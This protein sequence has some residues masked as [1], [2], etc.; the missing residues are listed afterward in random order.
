MRSETSTQC[1]SSLRL[2]LASIEEDRN[3]IAAQDIV[4]GLGSVSIRTQ[5]SVSSPIAEPLRHESGRTE[6]RKEQVRRSDVVFP[7]GLRYGEQSGERYPRRQ[8]IG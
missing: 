3:R 6:E 8:N 1:P 2:R 5:R 4:R 7:S